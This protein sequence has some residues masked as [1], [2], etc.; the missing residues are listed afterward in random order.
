VKLSIRH[1]GLDPASIFF[2]F[3]GGKRTGGP[4][5]KSGVTVLRAGTI[6]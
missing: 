5:I 6:A 3:G 1:A 2:F 4:R